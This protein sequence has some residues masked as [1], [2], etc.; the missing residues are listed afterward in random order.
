VKFQKLETPLSPIAIFDMRF[1]DFS[2]K[3]AKIHLPSFKKIPTQKATPPEAKLLLSE[4]N[5]NNYK[6]IEVKNQIFT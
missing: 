1:E 4:S 5:Q 6:K 3:K 2:L